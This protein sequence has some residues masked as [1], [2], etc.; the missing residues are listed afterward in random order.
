MSNILEPSPLLARAEEVGTALR[1]AFLPLL[2]ADGVVFRPSLM[3]RRFK[4]DKSLAARLARALKAESTLELVHWIPS[5]QGLRIVVQGMRDA[6]L[7]EAAVAPATAAIEMF[8]EL[9]DHTDGGRASLDAH[10]AKSE[11]EVRRRR[12]ET[13]KQAVNRGMEFL[14]GFSCDVL[15]TT[16]VLSRSADDQHVDA[17]ELHHR[18]GMRRL[19]PNTPLAF[20]SLSLSANEDGT[21]SGP[22]LLT[23]DGTPCHDDPTAVMLREYSSDPL[24]E[25]EIVRE[26]RH[27]IFAL[28]EDEAALSERITLTSGFRYRHGWDIATSPREMSRSYL[29]HYP[30]R[31]LIRDIYLDVSLFGDH[32]PEVTLEVPSPAG[33]PEV[34][35]T[36]RMAQLAGVDLE[37]PV[38]A[39][40]PLPSEAGVRGAPRY[41]DMLSGAFAAAGWDPARFRGYRA[42]MSYPTPMLLMA[43]WTTRLENAGA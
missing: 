32:V 29:L 38:Q 33:A 4:L 16:L 18:L 36:G 3:T 31:Q 9:I 7:P 27:A 23:L 1:Q 13:S 12:E 10:V 39:L 40:P 37:V 20:L 35:R 34:R 43:W 8:R 42:T 24:P 5:P 41:G 22:Q 6:G 19:R 11:L 15:V 14:L 30:C 28:P 2:S 21:N 26:G 25:L 17:L